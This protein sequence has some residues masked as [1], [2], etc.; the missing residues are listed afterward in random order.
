MSRT[1]SSRFSA[2]TRVMPGGRL[3]EIYA[4]MG[5]RQASRRAEG[6]LSRAHLGHFLGQ[7]LGPEIG[8]H[9]L[10]LRRTARGREKAETEKGAAKTTAATTDEARI[11]GDDGAGAARAGGATVGGKWSVKLD[12]S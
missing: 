11:R 10:S 1:H 8:P 3:L 4:H 9:C 7:A 2:E 6:S 12:W 5:I